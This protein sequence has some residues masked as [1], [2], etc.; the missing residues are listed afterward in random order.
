MLT[1]IF[2]TG[3]FSITTVLIALGTALA[4]GI[5]CSAIYMLMGIY[6]KS[7]VVVLAAL[8]MLV[9]MIIM[10]VNGN[11]GASVAVL[12]AFGLVRFRSAPGSARD[13]GFIFFSMSI[14]LTCG[15]GFLTLA[16]LMT[17]LVGA[18]LLALYKSPF[19]NENFTERALRITVPEDLNYVGAFDEV[20]KAYTLNHKL[21]SCK[22]TNMGTMYELNYRVTLCNQFLEKD[23]MDALR[24]R[25]GNLTIVLG[26]AQTDRESL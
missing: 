24:C 22:T 21:I 25:N 5:A 13:M 7:F 2:H 15:M 3:S 19:G 8:P 16:A 9:T 20:F 11:V 17:V 14:G 23:F 10:V 1:S 12:G 6:R 26:L 4:L 18:A